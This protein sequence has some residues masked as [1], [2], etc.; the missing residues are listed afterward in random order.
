MESVKT[1]TPQ[2]KNLI[3]GLIGLS[4]WK[5]QAPLISLTFLG[6]LIAHGAY[7]IQLDWRLFVVAIANFL[8]VTF[9]FMINDME[10]AEDDAANPISAKRNPITNGT[11][12]L[13][14][15]WIACGVVVLLALGFYLVGGLVVLVIGII[16]LTLSFLYSWKPVRLKSSTIG[17][18]VV[19]HTLMLGGLLPLAGYFAYTNQIHPAII[20]ASAACTLGSVYGQLYNQVRDFDADKKAGIINVTIRVGKKNAFML[21]YGAIVASAVCGVLVVAAIGLPEW[22]LPTIAIS[23]AIGV[24]ATFL[25]IRTDSSGKPPLDITGRLQSGFLLA[26]NIVMIVW[27]LWAMG[28][29]LG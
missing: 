19:S 5:E 22:L 29:K 18:D 28:V 11:L 7:A 24:A 1:P 20:F 15:A 8:T 27:V 10:D 23:I 16:N 2:T 6:G 9:A 21:M 4:R 25:F 12:D 17:L 26:F 14:T 13:P 3:K